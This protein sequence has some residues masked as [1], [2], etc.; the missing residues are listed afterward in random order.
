MPPPVDPGPPPDIFEI[1]F[2]DEVPFWLY[3]TDDDDEDED[4]VDESE[5]FDEGVVDT[6]VTSGSDPTVWDPLDVD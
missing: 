2:R 1:A 4:N 3:G 5:L 6:G